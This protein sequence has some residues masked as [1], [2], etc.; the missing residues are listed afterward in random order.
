M[1][2]IIE[3]TPGYLPE[4]DDPPMFEDRTDALVCLSD[5]LSRYLDYLVDCEVEFEIEQWDEGYYVT[6]KDSEHDLGRIFEVVEVES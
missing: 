4:N 3:N 5:E 6:R 2:T 1:F